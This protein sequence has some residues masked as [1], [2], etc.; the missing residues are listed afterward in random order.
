LSASSF[1]VYNRRGSTLLRSYSSETRRWGPQVEKP[2]AGIRYRALRQLGPVVVLR[3]VA[4]WHTRNAAISVRLDG[5]PLEAPTDDDVCSLPYKL[6]HCKL[7]EHVLAV[8]PKG[9]LRFLAVGFAAFKQVLRATPTASL[10]E[11]L[12]KK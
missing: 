10:L 2:D 1:L 3:G 7:D 6:P 9:I 5:A 11:L 8:S 4:Y 12:L